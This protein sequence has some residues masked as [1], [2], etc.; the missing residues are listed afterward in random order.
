MTKTKKPDQKAKRR[1]G[2]VTRKAAKQQREKSREDAKLQHLIPDGDLKRCS[3]CGYPF[4]PDVKPSVD[5]AFLEHL[6]TA[7]KP[8]QTTEDV[9][10]AAFRIVREATKD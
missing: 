6:R 5:V 2:R 8:G 7:H 1:E 10:Q 9:S 3:V 4:P